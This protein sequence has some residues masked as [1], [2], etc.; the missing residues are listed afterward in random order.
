M[1]FTRLIPEACITPGFDASS[2]LIHHFKKY[3]LT[4]WKHLSFFIKITFPRIKYTTLRRVLD[5]FKK[6]KICCFFAYF[7]TL[8]YY[9]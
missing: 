9:T 6:E 5:V 3:T 8:H 2:I 4:T 1:N 7:V